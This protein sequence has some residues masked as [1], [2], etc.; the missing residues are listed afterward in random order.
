M[1]RTKQQRSSK[2]RRQEKK[3]SPFEGL[4]KNL[5]ED[6]NLIGKWAEIMGM[7]Q[8]VT[9]EQIEEEIRGEPIRRRN[10][11]NLHRTPRF[12][13]PTAFIV[14]EVSPSPQVPDDTIGASVDEEW[15]LVNPLDGLPE[16]APRGIS[17]FR[18]LEAR[19]REIQATR[20]EEL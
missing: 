3:E 20:D 13:D 15:T 19:I 9:R 4:F 17:N 18:E 11:F 10:S 8:P 1:K 5:T 7:D 6:E 14:F 16:P 12:A 2:K